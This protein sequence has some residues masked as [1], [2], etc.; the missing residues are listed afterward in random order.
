MDAKKCNKCGLEKNIT[1]YHK[2]SQTNTGYSTWCKVCANEYA[3]SHRAKNKEKSIEKQREYATNNRQKMRQYYKTYYERHREKII[4]SKVI[5]NNKRRKIRKQTDPAYKI[6]CNL[7]R[8]IL[9]AVNGKKK[10]FSTFDLIGCTPDFLKRY[11]ES[12]FLTDM[13]WDNYGY[14]GWHIDHILPCASF[15]LT[16]PEQQRKCFHY[17]NL[18]P[19][20]AKDNMA[21]GADVLFK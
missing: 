17:T 2:H 18:Q 12:K 5:S 8:R 9:L 3:R 10:M 13:S 19:L 14:K 16:D 4:K 1:D 20:W 21:K 6:E 7:R 11:L 15:D